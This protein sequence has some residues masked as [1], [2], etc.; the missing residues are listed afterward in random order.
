MLCYEIILGGLCG[1]LGLTKVRET[2][3]ETSKE[4]KKLHLLRENELLV[5]SH[6]KLGNTSIRNDVKY[7]RVYPSFMNVI[8]RHFKAP[9]KNNYRKCRE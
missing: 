4:R 2:Q 7:N 5:P 6:D 1:W 3:H 9:F 8:L